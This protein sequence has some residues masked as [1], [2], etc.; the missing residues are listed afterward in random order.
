MWAIV[1]WIAV[2]LFAL[3]LI[4]LG[5]RKLAT[6]A[7]AVVGAVQIGWLALTFPDLLR[8][9][10][11]MAMSFAAAL[12]FLALATRH[13]GAPATAM[14]W[15]GLVLLAWHLAL[16]MWGMLVPDRPRQMVAVSVTAVMIL[17][18]PIAAYLAA[19]FASYPLPQWLFDLPS[20]MTWLLRPAGLHF[21]PPA[22]I[23]P[24]P[25]IVFGTGATLRLA[26]ARGA[27]QVTSY[28]HRG[29]G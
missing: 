21:P 6:S 5:G 14:V 17:G 20:P 23:W 27:A 26:R 19:E 22:E 13:D 7:L 11:A 2:Q 1:A 12:P 25:A 8:G 29:G 10:R 4:D 24:F 3:V 16:G 9:W 15:V 18:T 28:P